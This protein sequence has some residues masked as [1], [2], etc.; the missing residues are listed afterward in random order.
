MYI[1]PLQLGPASQVKCSRPRGKEGRA[2]T[3]NGRDAL[4][5]CRAPRRS[6]GDVVI[7]PQATRQTL[8][9]NRGEAHRMGGAR[10]N[11]YASEVTKL[12]RRQ[13]K[14]G[15]KKGNINKCHSLRRYHLQQLQKKLP[16]PTPPSPAPQQ[17]LNWHPPR[18]VIPPCSS[19]EKT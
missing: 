15:K 17:P 12:L 10:L 9:S 16:S 19:T 3:G 4:A 6:S 7:L 5:L 8:V 11:E 14:T 18:A 13:D 2:V 1:P